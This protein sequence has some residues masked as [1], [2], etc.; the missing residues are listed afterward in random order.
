MKII[1]KFELTGERVDKIC[2]RIPLRYRNAWLED[3]PQNV[4]K[5]IEVDSKDRNKKGVFLFGKCGTGKTHVLMSILKN[6]NL[7]L[8]KL[9]TEWVESKKKKLEL[10]GKPYDYIPELDINLFY[11]IHNST[12]LSA[13]FRREAVSDYM[14]DEKLNELLDD[15]KNSL[16]IDDFCSEKYSEYIEECFYRI[17][18]KR[19]ENSE[20]PLFISSN[21]SLQEISD[22]IGDR[23]ASRIA[24]MCEIIKLEGDDQRLN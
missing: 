11:K 19:W 2:E 5:V 23:I 14:K 4:L 1:K 16:I 10:V 12:E 13:T 8:Y 20:A 6:M 7:N 3:A 24:G 18:N 22:R 21:F 9:H 17:L 15:I